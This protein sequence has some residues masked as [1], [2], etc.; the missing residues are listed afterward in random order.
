[1]MNTLKKSTILVAG[2]ASLAMFASTPAFATCGQ[3]E[4][5]GL[6]LDVWV[7]T[8]KAIEG[9]GSVDLTGV[10]V[11][12]TGEIGV[13]MP[14]PVDNAFE[15]SQ[16]NSGDING[17]LKYTG[18]WIAGNFVSTNTAIANN[19]SVSTSGSAVFE[20]VQDN[21]GDVAAQSD[22]DMLHL[23]NIKGVDVNVTAVGNNMSFTTTSDLVLDTLQ[24]NTGDVYASSDVL[25]MGQAS[26]TTADVNVATTAIGNNLSGNHDGTIIGSAI[27]ENCGD[28]TAVSKV[29]VRGFYDPITVTAVGN[30]INIAN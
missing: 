11:Q 25:L 13:N 4:V 29:D 1:M 26:L 23:V 24:N 27:Q 28:I 3:G 16:T 2:A 12:G 22:I 17:N 14:N 21:G 15:F 10:E 8:G 7:N 19:A 20:G 30:N 5:C 18:S 9:L 6:D